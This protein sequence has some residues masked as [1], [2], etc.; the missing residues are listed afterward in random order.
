MSNTFLMTINREEAGL[1]LNWIRYFEVEVVV[2]WKD[3]PEDK[4]LLDRLVE[5]HRTP[6]DFDKAREGARE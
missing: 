6:F 2:S 1:L 5:F 4:K 3:Y